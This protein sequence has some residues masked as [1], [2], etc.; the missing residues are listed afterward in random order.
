MSSARSNKIRWQRSVMAVVAGEEI[1]AAIGR[2]LNEMEE[3]G[4]EFEATRP[5]GI[6]ESIVAGAMCN[7]LG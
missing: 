5:V 4:V 1:R 7:V 6:L 3:A 2:A